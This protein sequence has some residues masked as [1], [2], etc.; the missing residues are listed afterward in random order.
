MGSSLRA[1]GK[2]PLPSPK[3]APSRAPAIRARPKAKAA[4]H[5]RRAG[6]I[7]YVG[8]RKCSMSEKVASVEL[9]MQRNQ[10]QEL[11]EFDASRE[12]FE[13]V[14]DPLGLRDVGECRSLVEAG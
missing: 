11:L 1:A 5:D 2:R 10:C 9:R 14:H 8:P 6:A 7:V 4:V 12:S 3:L 13:S